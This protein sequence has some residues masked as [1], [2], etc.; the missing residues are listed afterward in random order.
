[1]SVT[2]HTTSGNRLI[3]ALPHEDRQ[4]FLGSCERVELFLGDIL[5]KVGEPIQYVYFPSSGVISL[6]AEVDDNSSVEVG[7]V[8]NEGM[9]G[10]PIM[11]GVDS[12]SLKL[13]VLGSGVAW[14]MDAL[15]FR[16]ELQLNL[17][18]KLKLNR[19]LYVITSQIAQTVA[20]TRFHMVEARLSRWLLVMEDRMHSEKFQVTHEIIANMLGVRR[21][22][23]T[24]AAGSLQ[25]KKLISYSRGDIM[26]LDRSGLEAA[27][28]GCY[29]ANREVYDLVLG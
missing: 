2:K 22:A 4:H 25:R 10:I 5:C 12:S 21:V 8:G 27:C 29:R 3:A 14:R 16:R 6:L 13:L 26:I 15:S 1:M 9:I 20:C 28:C 17:A 18:L 19:Y 24:N 7:M 23:V 11:F